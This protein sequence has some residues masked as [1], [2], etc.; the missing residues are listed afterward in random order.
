MVRKV[1]NS[2]TNIEIQSGVYHMT[3]ILWKSNQRERDHSAPEV[4]ILHLWFK[5]APSGE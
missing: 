5:L 4:P 2:E 3:E 1:L